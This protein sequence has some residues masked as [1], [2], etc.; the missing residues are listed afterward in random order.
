[1]LGEPA[2]GQYSATRTASSMPGQ[3]GMVTMTKVSGSGPG[4][5]NWN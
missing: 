5:R 4:L 1:M 3:G 2:G